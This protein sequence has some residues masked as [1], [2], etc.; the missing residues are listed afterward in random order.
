MRWADAANWSNDL[1]PTAAD[2]VVI[3]LPG[4]AA[5]VLIDAW[6][7]V[8]INSLT[9]R[10]SLQ[11]GT[12]PVTGGSIELQ[13]DSVIDGDFT[14]I[15]SASRRGVG[16]LVLNGHLNWSGGGSLANKGTTILRG[17]GTFHL[18]G[19]QLGTGH[20]LILDSDVTLSSPA[21]N[22]GFQAGLFDETRPVMVKVTSG[23]TLMLSGPT[24]TTEFVSSFAAKPQLV[25]DAGATL[26]CINASVAPSQIDFATIVNGQ[27]DIV[28][29]TLYLEG[30]GSIANS[31]NIPA[32]AALRIGDVYTFGGPAN[33]INFTGAGT[34]ELF[35][36]FQTI[37]S[38]VQ[39]SSKLWI[40]SNVIFNA[41][42]TLPATRL[43]G[44]MAGAATVV[45]DG[46]FELGG[47]L[48]TS[49][50]NPTTFGGTTIVRGPTVVGKPGF[51]GTAGAI[52]EGRTVRFEAD[53]TFLAQGNGQFGGLTVSRSSGL[54]PP[55]RIEF[56]DGITVTFNE[57]QILQDTEAVQASI[58]TFGP[59]TLLR[60]VGEGMVDL[61]W[62]TIIQ[63]QVEVAPGSILRFSRGGS[64][65]DRPI[66]IP[67]S[68]TLSL[69]ESFDLG[70]AAGLQ[71]HGDIEYYS[72]AYTPRGSWSAA[73]KVS[74]RS[75]TLTVD[76]PWT[77]ASLTMLTSGAT[78][79][80]SADL[81]LSA[82]TWNGGAM[83]GTGRTTVTGVTLI[84]PKSTGLQLEQSRLLVLKGNA[85]LTPAGGF[86][87]ITLRNS[88]VLEIGTGASFTLNGD[89]NIA[90]AV[91]GS[92]LP[93]LR[94]RGKLIKSAGTSQ[95]EIGAYLD[96]Q[97]EIE[98]LGGRLRIRRNLVA[99]QPTG[100]FRTS[101]SGSNF[102]FLEAIS[103]F[104]AQL[105][106]GT[107]GSVIGFSTLKRNGGSIALGAG[108]S[109]NVTPAGGVL[110]QEGTLHADAGAFFNI[111]GS[112]ASG[113]ASGARFST[114][115]VSAVSFGRI[116]ISG[117]LDLTD[118]QSR[119]T[120]V[121]QI[122]DEFAP[123]LSDRFTVITAA[124]GVVGA[125][126]DF[127]PVWSTGSGQR[128]MHVR[129]SATT[130][131]IGVASSASPPTVIA[132]DMEDEM[133]E[134]VLVSFDQDVTAFLA[135]DD[136]RILRVDA[137]G[138]VD[139]TPSGLALAYDPTSQ[140]AVW[141]L[142]NRLPN[143]RYRAVL[144][145]EDV[146][147]GFGDALASG[148]SLDFPILR[149]DVNRDGI[150]GFD[151]LLIVA[152]QYGQG[153][154]G[155]SAGNVDFSADGKVDFNDLLLLAQNYGASAGQSLGLATGS[156][157]TAKR[158]TR[159]AELLI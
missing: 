32:D 104:N 67:A 140:R 112:V 36:G 44:T 13:A 12:S 119:V 89:A 80:G 56:A 116:L 26:R 158:S 149:G 121:T 2:D 58:V 144:A 66:M 23:H 152:Q 84:A 108:V 54:A 5:T 154:L 133:R 107:G 7:E 87:R 115:I 148:M 141:T 45:I 65:I 34:L 27:I 73:T 88:S 118:L 18:G 157:R 146:R 74:I 30:G 20:H 142:T 120:L 31:V 85:S 14:V 81:T 132:Q 139:V 37:N 22:G 4:V 113:G 111:T 1:L 15:G 138:T 51:N 128:L 40:N 143:G 72:G 98:V 110:R 60:T 103:D 21:H 11:I 123:M 49:V 52:G 101:G 134:A 55:A 6:T 53:V 59:N 33:P 130:L 94:N 48:G 57:S 47:S 147:N 76:Q 150:V 145:A 156:L 92:P 136:L 93:T 10:E 125:V 38:G 70:S 97:G 99:A 153:G 61:N 41:D 68:A 102:E 151:D 43:T 122:E 35:S 42:I 50:N 24:H 106:I 91:A 75:A 78:L 135:A 63:G 64:A 126:D 90:M 46:A 17:G 95:A 117:A 25:I 3:D 100:I 155:R 62:R 83:S 29:G 77:W 124:E 28:Q 16:T 131:A 86:D 39:I 159:S 114:A 71:M 96:N 79:T 9:C 129:P 105:Q 8:K 127:A 19:L 69:G 82:F 137:E 109:L